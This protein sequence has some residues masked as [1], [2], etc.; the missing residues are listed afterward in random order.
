MP[1]AP[2]F[3]PELR[4]ALDAEG[5]GEYCQLLGVIRAARGSF[6]LFFIESDFS[7]A[8]R[9]MLLDCL[10]VDLAGEG[11]RLR[12]VTL[13]AADKELSRLAALETPAAL[14]EV[15]AL[16]GLEN[17]PDLVRE[18]GRKPERPL[19]Y[20]LLNQGREALRSRLPAPF[21]VWCTPSVY[22][23]LQTHAPDFFDHY[24]GLFQFLAAA[25]AIPSDRLP[26]SADFT[27]L[28]SARITSP[29]AAQSAVKFYEEQ[30]AQHP[31]PTPERAHALLGLADALLRL[32][33][34]DYPKHIQRSIYIVNE[35]FDLLSPER[36]PYEWARGQI[37]KGIAYS[38]LPV[39]DRTQNLQQAI[40]CFQAALP[41]IRETVLPHEWAMAQNNLGSAYRDL[42][43]G[44]R[45]Q[46]LLRA[47]DCYEAAL[48]VRTENNFP[49]EWVSTQSNLGIAYGEL[50]VGDRTQNLQQ[51]IACFQ[52]ALRIATEADFPY[53]WGSTQSNLGIAYGELPVGD[54]TQNLQQAIACFQAALRVYN[55]TNFPN[56]W[57]GTQSNLG[58]AY[59]FLPAGDRTLN[60]L[61]AI[62]CYEAALSV[63]TEAEFPQKWAATQ[64]NLALTLQELGNLEAARLALQCAVVGY[65]Q[66]GLKTSAALAENL[67]NLL[68]AE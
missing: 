11:L 36:D 2:S 31:H 29:A 38:E 58:V 32:Y 10:R 44:D 49:H 1:E 40:A 26:I 25:P 17:T 51:A 28:P 30:I 43:I 66:V 13:T 5:E 21:L 3:P 16:V 27:A 37:I 62:D 48:R 59:H 57:A 54:R 22:D 52:A 61:C 19:V 12:Q 68:N 65:R 46:N 14:D 53:K 9:D 63:Y 18:P 41:T 42:P 56:E 35:A 7:P 34:P 15:I 55:K 20:A 47:I 60:L 39:G 50:P 67:L 6:F 23:G 45:T 4:R 24:A 33:G 8:V 64:Y